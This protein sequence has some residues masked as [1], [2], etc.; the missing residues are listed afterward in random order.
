MKRSPRPQ[1]LWE[2]SGEQELDLLA[3]GGNIILEE[4]AQYFGN[5][6]EI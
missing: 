6:T 4:W 1:G 3:Q 2:P 5:T